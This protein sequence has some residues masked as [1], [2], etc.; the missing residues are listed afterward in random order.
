MTRSGHSARART[1]ASCADTRSRIDARGGTGL[2]E[3]MSAVAISTIS[4]ASVRTTAR[5]SPQDGADPEDV[6]HRRPAARPGLAAQHAPD[7]DALADDVRPQQ[8]PPGGSRPFIR[9]EE[10]ARQRSRRQAARRDS[11]GRR[12]LVDARRCC[13]SVRWRAS[14]SRRAACRAPTPMP[15]A[16]ASTPSP[17]AR[18]PR[19]VFALSVDLT[20]SGAVWLTT[21]G[22]D[23]GGC[24]VVWRRT[25]DDDAWVPLRQVGSDHRP[26]QIRMAD[27]GADGLIGGAGLWV[28]H[29][30]GDSWNAEPDVPVASGRRGA[31]RDRRCALPGPWY[32]ARGRRPCSGGR[33]STG[34]TGARSRCRPRSIPTPHR[35]RSAM[36][37]CSG[38]PAIPTPRRVVTR[39]GGR[40]WQPLDPP[41]ARGG[42]QVGHRGGVHHLPVPQGTGGG[43]PRR[44]ARGRR[45]PLAAALGP[46]ASLSP[47]AAASSFATGARRDRL[48]RRPRRPAGQPRPG[49]TWTRVE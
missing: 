18:E 23:C 16:Q 42:G 5:P 28:T 46:A 31:G 39:D 43:R 29:D 12:R 8:V 7:D 6:G 27:S 34:P 13:S 1:C 25:P 35:S 40:T 10:H 24:V 44:T 38:W 3:T 2:P 4:P 32:V 37:C 33:P 11:V 41:C 19:Q 21:A 49:R 9:H 14:A 17:P 30:G 22:A 20:R 48:R 45:W 15:P 47:Q 36:R 26:G